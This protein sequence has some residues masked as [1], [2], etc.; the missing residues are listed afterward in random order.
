MAKFIK[1]CYG[2]LNSFYGYRVHPITGIRG[3]FH[4]GIDYTGASD[5]SI[6]ATAAGK[7]RFL[8]NSPT[9]TGFGKYIIITHDNGYESVYAHLSS[10]TVKLGQR[11]KQ[12]QK[13]G[14]KGTT[15]NSTGMHLHFEIS[16]GRWNNRYTTNV[17]P[18]P[19]ISDPEIATVQTVLK[20][21]GL[22]TGSID[23]IHGTKSIA[24][25]K[26][27][28]KKKGMG[29]DGVPGRGTM[30]AV[31]AEQKEQAK[32]KP[33]T[34]PKPVDKPKPVE[35][36]PSYPTAVSDR[37]GEVQ[38]KKDAVYRY[39]PEDNGKVISTLKKG[40]K[41]HYYDINGHWVRLGKGW[42]KSQGGSVAE[43][44][45]KYNEPTEEEEIMELKQWQ[46]EEL[47]DIYKDARENKKII[48]SDEHEVAVMNG[49]LTVSDA[50]YLN[51]VLAGAALNG[52]KRQKQ[53]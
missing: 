21:D 33:A 36:I 45:K 2:Y 40:H 35:K 44:T 15:G 51:G 16:K 31:F 22:Y 38:L 48:T 41:C 10:I 13:I 12:G 18:L 27:F 46:K 34:K 20:A 49:T 9:R 7:I 28:Q 47:R 53:Q 30:A 52:D 3:T 37:L 43:I 39:T 11:V 6:F 23:G 24:A 25:V 5:E 50:I 14:V 8:D 4:R 32:V 1:P 26:A 29:V 19:F 42:V 17:D